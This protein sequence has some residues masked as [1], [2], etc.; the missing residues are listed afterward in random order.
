MGRGLEALLDTSD[1]RT[2]GS[3]SIGEVDVMLIRPN[4]DQPR[5]EF[6]E[7]HLREL[8]DSIAQIS[9]SPSPCVIR[10]TDSIPS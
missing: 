5:R 3:S 2:G 9:C 10:A 8:A 1:V 7:E 6:S 4:P